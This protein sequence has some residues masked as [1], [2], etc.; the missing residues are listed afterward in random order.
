MSNTSSQNGKAPSSAGGIRPDL[1]SPTGYWYYHPTKKRRVRDQS[2]YRRMKHVWD[3]L[4][5][6]PDIY[7]PLQHQWMTGKVFLQILGYLVKPEP[8]GFALQS[9]HN[10]MER[11][12]GHSLNADDEHSLQDKSHLLYRVSHDKQQDDKSGYLYCLSNP[13]TTVS[14]PIQTLAWYKQNVLQSKSIDDMD[15][16]VAQLQEKYEQIQQKE[17]AETATTQTATETTETTA[18][19]AEASTSTS[20]CTPKL[21]AAQL[22]EQLQNQDYFDSAEAHKLFSPLP[23]LTVKET[24]QQRIDLLQEAQHLTNYGIVWN[25][26]GDPNRLATDAEVLRLRQRAALLCLAYQLALQHMGKGAK[27]WTECRNEAAATL[28]SVGFPSRTS[29]PSSISTAHKEFKQH[30]K[31]VRPKSL[32][33][34]YEEQATAA[35]LVQAANNGSTTITSHDDAPPKRPSGSYVFF[36]L[37]MRPQLKAEHPGISFSTLSNLLGERWR[38]LRDDERSVFEAQARQDKAR[39][40]RERQAYLARQQQ[41][42]Q[43]HQN[44]ATTT[45]SAAAAAPYESSSSSS[46]DEGEE[47]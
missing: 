33:L 40:D 45:S 22:L 36:T 44:S 17:A 1:T 42:Q 13:E 10:H 3:L 38:N 35:T 41:K 28:I 21:T 5:K 47:D 34:R 6:T 26:G 14:P 9:L 19:T 27:N 29:T 8:L 16:F 46:E 12:V 20:T 32:Q 7:I 43:Q 15:S 11:V 31:F 18:T 25:D 2:A 24:L 4:F 23:G 30:S 37:Q 39:Y